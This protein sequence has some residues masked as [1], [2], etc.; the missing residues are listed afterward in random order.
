MGLAQGQNRTRKVEMSLSASER[1]QVRLLG[2]ISVCLPWLCLM[3]GGLEPFAGRP[4]NLGQSSLISNEAG[5][6]S[7]RDTKC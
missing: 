1:G 5:S 6:A 2:L 3:Q 7:W 4:S